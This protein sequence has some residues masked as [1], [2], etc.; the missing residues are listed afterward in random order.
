MCDSQ[1]L[2]NGVE[3]NGVETSATP[4]KKLHSP[5]LPPPPTNSPAGPWLGAQT[6]SNTDSPSTYGSA[7]PQGGEAMAEVINSPLA[8][9]FPGSPPRGQ[10]SSP[11]QP[12]NWDL[13][14]DEPWPV[15]CSS[16]QR[17][18][19]TASIPASSAL[20]SSSAEVVEGPGKDPAADEYSLMSTSADAAAAGASE[21]NNS[22]IET[23]SSSSSSQNDDNST[24]S[25]TT[26]AITAEESSSTSSSC[27][28]SQSSASSVI[29][30]SSNGNIDEEPSGSSTSNQTPRK[31]LRRSSDGDDDNCVTSDMVT[32]PWKRQKL[33]QE[34]QAEEGGN[35]DTQEAERKQSNPSISPVDSSEAGKWAVNYRNLPVVKFLSQQCSQMYVT[36]MQF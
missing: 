27:V 32:S 31:S 24:E 30:Q 9:D 2:L 14:V 16:P 4:A 34:E 6:A 28:A 21:T 10:D 22:T 5:F 33:D 23:A 19:A 29:S 8:E 20:S 13:A 17:D 36:F 18:T 3:A 7:W 35:C 1:Y 11:L 26:E 12:P 25:Q 15:Q